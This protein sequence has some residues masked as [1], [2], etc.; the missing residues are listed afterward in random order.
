MNEDKNLSSTFTDIMTTVERK[1]NPPL[2][3]KSKIL[4]HHQVNLEAPDDR[5]FAFPLPPVFQTQVTFAAAP[6]ADL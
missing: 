6:T 3:T 5:A 1:Y 2:K 4:L